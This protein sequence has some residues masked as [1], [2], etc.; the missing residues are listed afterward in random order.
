MEPEDGPRI[1]RLILD[2]ATGRLVFLTGRVAGKVGFDVRSFQ[3]FMATEPPDV[4][5]TGS[6]NLWAVF[7]WRRNQ[8][9]KGIAGAQW[10]YW[11]PSFF[12]RTLGVE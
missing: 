2:A 3:E 4:R 10:K 8:Y 12:Q 9:L 11:L 1:K 5:L 6:A 7:A